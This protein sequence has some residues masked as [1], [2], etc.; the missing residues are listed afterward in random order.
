MYEKNTCLFIS[1]LIGLAIV[2]ASASVSGQGI[3]PSGKEMGLIH[4]KDGQ[5]DL[6]GWPSSL[7]QG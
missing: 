1:L 5:L 4:K 6:P 3:Q 2:T 7:G